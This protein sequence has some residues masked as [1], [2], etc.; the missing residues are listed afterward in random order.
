MDWDEARSLFLPLYARFDHRESLK[1]AKFKLAHYTSLEVMKSIICDQEVWLS[2]PLFMNDWE[3]MRFGIQAGMDIFFSAEAV[4]AAAGSPT[5]ADILKNEVRRLHERLDDSGAFDIYVLCL[6]EHDPDNTD[7]RLSMWRAYG[8]QGAGAAIVFDPTKAPQD[9]GHPLVIGKV[10]YASR[11]T[12]RQE[13]TALIANWCGLV[14]QAAP[15]DDE[16]KIAAQFIFDLLKSYAL[17]TKHDG[18]SEE[19]EW[20]VIYIPERDPGRA[21]KDALS[22][23][24]GQR[25]V[26]PKLKLKAE[27]AIGD[28]GIQ[29][30]D[31]IDSIILGPSISS[32]LS[33]LGIE[34]MFEIHGISPKPKL[35]AST[36]PLRTL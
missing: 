23:I 25:G 34:R 19:R 14:Q 22:Y 20:R 18:F 6:S 17:T 10:T 24:I 35:V 32:G 28:S 15:N 12:R 36:I 31:L 2:N 21:Y 27:T 9:D 7:G 1:K 29:F 30:L 26:E 5:R 3:E 33:Q 11:E 8:K 4:D 16:L 13:I